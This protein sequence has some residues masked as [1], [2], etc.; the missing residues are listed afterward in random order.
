MIKNTV[1]GMKKEL[2]EWMEAV[3]IMLQHEKD[4][5]QGMKHHKE[6][7]RTGGSPDTSQPSQAKCVYTCVLPLIDSCQHPAI[8][9]NDSTCK[10]SAMDQWV[11]EF[12]PSNYFSRMALLIPMAI[13]QDTDQTHM[14]TK[15]TL[16]MAPPQVYPKMEP[17]SKVSPP[18]E[19]FATKGA[20][21]P[22]LYG[23]RR[24]SYAV[25]D[26]RIIHT[27]HLHA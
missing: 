21:C 24:V 4:K 12:H 15:P 2:K 8:H 22:R 6:S 23:V 10:T 26:A 11:Q 7:K 17:P 20:R 16:T 13:N 19:P 25:S 5:N 1:T 3:K 18:R 9:H 27:Q 14:N